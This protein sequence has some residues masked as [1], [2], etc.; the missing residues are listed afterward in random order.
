MTAK[1][2]RR[3]FMSLLGGAAGWPLS[4]PQKRAAGEC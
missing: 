3:E 2:N 4:A 1:M